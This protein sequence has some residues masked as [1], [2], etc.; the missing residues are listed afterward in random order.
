MNNPTKYTKL[1]SDIKYEELFSDTKYT[2]LLMIFSTLNI[3][4][5]NLPRLYIN[6]GYLRYIYYLTTFFIEFLKMSNFDCSNLTSH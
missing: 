1:F 6:M 4:K 2:K 3:M 5:Y